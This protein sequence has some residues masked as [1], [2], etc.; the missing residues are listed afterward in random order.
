MHNLLLQHFL[1]SKCD[2]TTRL[3]NSAQPIKLM[4]TL[5]LQNF[6]K[7]KLQGLQ[8]YIARLPGWPPALIMII[9]RTLVEQNLLKS[10]PLGR[11]WQHA[12]VAIDEASIYLFK[13]HCS[14]LSAAAHLGAAELPEVEAAWPLA[15]QWWAHAPLGL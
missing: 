14:T 8:S 5:V 1:K 2:N 12:V 4:R 15:L 13:R 11:C 10:K 9:R 3:A 7:S 6:L